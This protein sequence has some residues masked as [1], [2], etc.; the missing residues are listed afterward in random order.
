[1]PEV[2][3]RLTWLVLKQGHLLEFS[4]RLLFHKHSLTRASA[5]AHGLLH[6]FNNGHSENFTIE[7]GRA[8][9]VQVYTCAVV[10]MMPPRTTDKLQS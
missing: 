6:R 10:E 3:S 7:R 5:Q 4:N 2:V 9:G 1:M 8:E